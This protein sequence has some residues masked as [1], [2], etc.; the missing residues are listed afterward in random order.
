M[1]GARLA[2]V[3]LVLAGCS[4]VAI[5]TAKQCSFVQHKF[6]GW[7]YWSDVKCISEEDY[8]HGHVVPPKLL[9]DEMR[10]ETED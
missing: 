6:V 2:I 4:S 8:R 3:L 5:S 9:L 1:S 10:S 7:D